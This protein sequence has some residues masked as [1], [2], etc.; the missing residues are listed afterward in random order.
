MIKAVVAGD[1]GLLG[2][3][4]KRHITSV[5]RQV[6]GISRSNTSCECHIKAD[7]LNPETY[8]EKVRLFEPDLIINCVGLVDLK[9]CEEKPAAAKKYNEETAGLLADLSIRLGCQFIHI[10][11]DQLFDG[12]K[13]TPYSETDETCPINQYGHSKRQGELAALATKPDSLVIRTNIVGKRGNTPNPS[14]AEW[15]D[16]QLRNGKKTILFTDYITSSAHVD[17]VAAYSLMALQKGATGILNIATRDAV[18]KYDF[19]MYYAKLQGYTVDNIIPGLLCD[20]NIFPPRPSNLTL[21]CAKA[22]ELLHLELPTHY[23]TITKLVR[24]FGDKQ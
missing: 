1:T 3:A 10:S 12:K 11:T 7:I 18:S 22:E 13:N 19:G 14:F 6:L 23:D 4:F 17:D 21:N 24:D 2:Q 15:L 20:V 16:N 5:G 9:K 8:L